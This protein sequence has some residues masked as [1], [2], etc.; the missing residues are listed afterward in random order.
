MNYEEVIRTTG[1][2]F[3]QQK[4]EFD[5][6]FNKEDEFRKLYSSAL[7]G[8]LKKS[9][10]RSLCWRILLGIFKK[11]DS[12]VESIK[13]SREDYETLS[14]EHIIDPRSMEGVDVNEFNP[15]MQSESNPWTKYF[16][17][18][19]LERIIKQDL[20][21]IYPEHPFFSEEIPQTIMAR[22]LFVWSKENPNPS[23]RQGMH[24]LLGPIFL[25]LW[26]DIKENTE[27]DELSIILDEKYL[28][29]DC[30][31][32]FAQLMTGMKEFYQIFENTS[33]RKNFP[34]SFIQNT[35][36]RIQNVIL[37]DADP[38]LSEYLDKHQIEPQIYGLK[39]VRLL[40]GREFEIEDTLILWDAIFAE[41]GG[42]NLKKNEKI[43]LKFIEYIGAVMLMHIGND[44]LSDEFNE[45][46]TLT[47]LMKFPRDK[48]AEYFVQN[49]CLLKKNKVIS[50]RT[51]H[52]EKKSSVQTLQVQEKNSNKLRD[53]IDGVFKKS[54]SFVQQNTEK[55][56]K[57]IQQDT[58]NFNKKLK[59]ST[60]SIAK[61][62]GISISPRKDVKLQQLLTQQQQIGT[63]MEKIIQ[64][65]QKEYL[66]PLEERNGED[67]MMA[68]AELKHI[69]DVLKYQI[70]LEN[71]FFQ[72]Q[73][74]PEEKVDPKQSRN[75]KDES[76]K[77]MKSQLSTKPI[78]KKASK[79]K[80]EFETD[81]DVPTITGSN[82]QE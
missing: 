6:L 54:T 55:I 43:D 79:K 71:S 31:T 62:I 53:S 29:H 7:T 13:T 28:E 60:N 68:L 59:E 56:N 80:I 26:R 3:E 48:S 61:G 72:F 57:K 33:N 27:N 17:N 40:F 35:C 24:E 9:T 46:D 74:K 10:I 1:S 58:G 22:V 42:N 45:C 70:P 11:T 14:K 37:K 16:E 39:W 4:A 69:K 77:P 2:S 23:Y 66:L 51:S 44:I 81:Y 34:D 64:V 67:T 41:S 19:E 32:I 50:L 65:L 38:M 12:F 25:V 52:L 76:N 20:L 18:Q 75:S 15:L 5:S 21:R 36:S 63:E 73:T 8:N 30:Y 78:K 49:A 82:I 47:I